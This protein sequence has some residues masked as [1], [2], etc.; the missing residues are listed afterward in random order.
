MSKLVWGGNRRSELERIFFFLI[1]N[2][3]FEKVF[4]RVDF[5]VHFART[6][7]LKKNSLRLLFDQRN[8]VCEP[9]EYSLAKYTLMQRLSEE[10]EGK[11]DEIEC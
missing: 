6:G 4:R 10:G 11:K 2:S 9:R 1:T 3:A 8:K 7:L 5:V